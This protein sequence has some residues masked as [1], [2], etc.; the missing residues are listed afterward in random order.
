[1]TRP[2]ASGRT[3]RV[4]YGEMPVAKADNKAEP[5]SIDARTTSSLVTFTPPTKYRSTRYG[6]TAQTSSSDWAKMASHFPT[7]IRK[8]VRRVRKVSSS[9][10]ALIS[11]LTAFS[12]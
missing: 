2:T 7:M 11:P 8:A 3:I 10:L 9:V 5:P 1:M 12:R 6:S 4:G